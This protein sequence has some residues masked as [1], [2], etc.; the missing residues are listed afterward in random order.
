MSKYQTQRSNRQDNPRSHTESTTK[1]SN[2]A[3]KGI[4]RVVFFAATLPARVI[5][6]LTKPPGSAILL[7]FGVL[8]FALVNI[9]GYWQ[10]LNVKHPP[11]LPKPFV[12]DGA[13]LIHLFGATPTSDFWVAAIFSLIVQGIQA[14]ALREQ[15]IAQAQ[16]SYEKVAQ[17]KVKNPVDGEIDL[18]AYRRRKLKRHGMKTVQF[19][20][21]LVIGTYLIDAAIALHNYPLIA[22]SLGQLLTHTVWVIASILGTEAA[23]NLFWA[24]IKPIEVVVEDFE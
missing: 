17:Y 15:T 13:D 4:W 11:F 9:E 10:A 1:Q 23:I 6:Y 8:Y 20:G 18:A 3:A 12:A 19:R 14:F 5:D 21:F 16:K 2:H 22:V 7:G 24:A